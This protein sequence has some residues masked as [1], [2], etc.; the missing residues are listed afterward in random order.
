MFSSF[1]NGLLILMLCAPAMGEAIDGPALVMRSCGKQADDA[2]VLDANGYAGTYVRLA[3]P[4]KVEISVD[5]LGHSSGDLKPRMNVVV[6]DNSKS[7]DVGSAVQ[8]CD[9]SLDLPAGT[10]FVRIEFVN[11]DTDRTLSIKNLKVNGA[12]VINK[13]SDA[14]ALTAADSY[15]EHFRK[16]D[17][18]VTLNHA[19]P[20]AEA[21]VK[22][23]R[24][25]FSFGTTIP[26]EYSNLIVADNP[27]AD[28]DA[29][30]CQE[31]LKRYF[32]TIIAGNA[33]KWAYNEP[34]SGKVTMEQIDTLID[35][36][37]SHGYRLRMHNLIWG[38]QQPNWVSVL[39]RKAVD[40]DDQAK[41]ELRKAISHR[42]G[43]YVH[44]RAAGYM[45]LDVLN[46]SLHQ[47]SYWKIFGAEG[48]AGIYKECADAV[49]AAG[50]DTR[51]YTNE[52]NILQWSHELDSNGK[53]GADDPYANWYLRNVQAINGAGGAVSA[54]GVQYYP[55]ISK[56]TQNGCPHSAA[57]IMQVFQ[58]LSVAGLPLTLTEF[59][60][61][62]G[63]DRTVDPMLAAQALTEAMR[64][65][66]GTAQMNGFIVW[67]FRKP[68]L[69]E[70]ANAGALF[71]AD[72]KLT[73]AG[74]Q[75]EDLMAR[76]D[77]NLMVPVGADGKI[78]FT[79]F[80]GD[81]EITV[82]QK[83]YP[84]TLTRQKSEYAP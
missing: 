69:W 38:N 12:E 32:N 77:T 19:A 57:R 1:R 24:H 30:K 44:D 27:P 6:A 13:N 4:G 42:I 61:Q 54:I 10:Y 68:W 28:S 7:F 52:Y 84:L 62:H 29:F 26:I 33:G 36:A 2:W 59:G 9:D 74:Q 66:F 18:V 64:M 39:I 23:K 75:F 5:A 49:H 20:G 45:D 34:E 71:E 8:T 65:S 78:H 60:V 17:A 25:A 81:Y 56:A 40:G 47:P 82:G 41:Q 35:F 3:S 72:W 51:L 76:W 14:I 11:H 63:R 48:I 50:T 67:G 16:E 80:L 37:K 79:G 15:I 70:H 31:F 58:N 22:L 53:E 83:S 43:Y 21:H 46:E 55:D 73:L